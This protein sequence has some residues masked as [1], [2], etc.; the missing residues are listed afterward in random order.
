MG[1]LIHTTKIISEWLSWIKKTSKH[2]TK[3]VCFIVL[4]S[5]IILWG[6]L[7][8]S[9]TRIIPDRSTMATST[10]KS[11]HLTNNNN[12]KYNRTSFHTIVSE[13]LQYIITIVFLS[14]QLRKT[15]YTCITI[16][17]MKGLNQSWWN[18][19][20]L[21]SSS[22]PLWNAILSSSSSSVSSSSSSHSPSSSS[23]SPS[24]CSPFPS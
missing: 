15:T 7:W 12:K 24:S 6:R 17:T 16:H 20:S 5:G 1:L 14:L 10:I 23:S 18:T 21:S 19:S 8:Y 3:G 4:I 13:K 11:K 9:S 22:S 2:S